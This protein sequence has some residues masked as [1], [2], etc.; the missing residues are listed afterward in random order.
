MNAIEKARASG[1]K[2]FYIDFGGGKLELIKNIESLEISPESTI[3]DNG[4]NVYTKYIIGI[5]VENKDKGKD[6]DREIIS[7]A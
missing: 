2:E 7:F 1:N 5:F 3:F 4:R 6:K